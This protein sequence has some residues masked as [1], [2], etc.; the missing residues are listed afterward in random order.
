MAISHQMRKYHENELLMEKFK[1]REIDL[2]TLK[3]HIEFE[4]MQVKYLSAEISAQKIASA[5][6]S[7]VSR[8]LRD[9]GLISTTS[10]PVV[11]V[12]QECYPCPERGN[13]NI[14]RSECLDYS[15]ASSHIDDCQKCKRFTETR[16][17]ICP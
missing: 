1:R 17:Q 12:I 15:G 16:K 8:H 11:N 13:C 7:K 5:E 2:E 10:I 6:G 9:A 4:S 3:A 14:T